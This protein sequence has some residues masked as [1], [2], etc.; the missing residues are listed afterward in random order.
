M[1][2]LVCFKRFIGSTQS[3]LSAALDF[4][5]QVTGTSEALLRQ[6]FVYADEKSCT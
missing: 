3:G 4:D 2:T 6:R 5:N 1:K